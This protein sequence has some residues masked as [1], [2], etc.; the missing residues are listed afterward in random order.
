MT[1][2]LSVLF[3]LSAFP[4]LWT[5]AAPPLEKPLRVLELPPGPG[6]PRNSEGD[7]IRL[8]D[9]GILFIYTRYTNGNGGDNDPACL[10]SRLSRDGGF[11]WSS[12][13]VEVVKNEGGMNVMSVSL[14]PSPIFKNRSWMTCSRWSLLCAYSLMNKSYF[15]VVK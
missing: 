14:R 11:T 7:L 4:C 15:P 13:P 12:D 6:N 9:G 8:K 10:V 3:A 5:Q 1:S 2:R